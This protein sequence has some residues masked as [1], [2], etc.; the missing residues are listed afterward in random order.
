MSRLRL[1][2]I[3]IYWKEWIMGMTH[4]SSSGFDDSPTPQK[5]L[6]PNPDPANFTIEKTWNCGRIL[7]ALLKYPDSTNFEGKKIMVYADLKDSELR[8]MARIDPHFHNVN[9]R[10]SPIA[11]FVPTGFGLE[12]AFNLAD[13]INRLVGYEIHESE[14]L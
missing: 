9:R 10:F 1:F 8:S 2:N 12:A 4:G 3:K 14:P 11:R 7:V 6:A 5:P 13:R